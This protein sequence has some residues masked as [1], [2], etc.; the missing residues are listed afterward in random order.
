MERTSVVPC[1]HE[2]NIIAAG[3]D[4]GNCQ[5][6][7]VSV[8]AGQNLVDIAFEEQGQLPGERRR[9]GEREEKGTAGAKSGERASLGGAAA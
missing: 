8:P 3:I 1:A 9:A 5:R 2:E 4:H 7:L 6:R